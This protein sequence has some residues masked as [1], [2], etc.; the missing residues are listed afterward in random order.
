MKLGMITKE[1]A[2]QKSRKKHKRICETSN[3]LT[4]FLLVSD[5]FLK[6]C[7]SSLLDE[8]RFVNVLLEELVPSPSQALLTK[9]LLLLLVPTMA[10]SLFSGSAKF[11]SEIGANGTFLKVGGNYEQGTNVHDKDFL[12]CTLASSVKRIAAM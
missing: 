12:A 7:S 3:T 5:S 9:H 4:G 10:F 2:K 8:V 6:K 1:A 11:I